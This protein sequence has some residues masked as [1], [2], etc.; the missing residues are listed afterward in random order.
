[1]RCIIVCIIYIFGFI[2]NFLFCIVV[3]EINVVFFFFFMKEDVGFM[4]LW[5]FNVLLFSFVIV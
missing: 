1:M 3:I 2:K 4:I 5:V